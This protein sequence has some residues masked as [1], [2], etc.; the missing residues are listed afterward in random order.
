VGRVDL[1]KI[2]ADSLRRRIAALQQD[3][4]V[5]DLPVFDNIALGDI[6]SADRRNVDRASHAAGVLDKINAL[7]RGF[8]TQLSLTLP[9]GKTDERGVTLSGGQLQRVAL[10]R[11]LMR[12]GCDLL[13]L[14]EPNS[15]LDAQAERAMQTRLASIRSGRTTL[16][17]THR[18][19]T[20]RGA[21]Q[22]CVVDDGRTV[23]TG[24][25]DDL[26]AR[27]GLYRGLF[28]AQAEGYADLPASAGSRPT[29]R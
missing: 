3:F 24:T 16:L 6:E 15:G 12:D 23:E 22:I 14:D 26:M 7:P 4:M 1:Q 19:S 8:D 20:V 10:A 29:R 2:S 5:Y 17:V 27:D 21:D 25:H 13:L 18:M 11:A 9:G 28:E